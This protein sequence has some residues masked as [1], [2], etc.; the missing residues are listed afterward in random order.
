MRELFVAFQP[1][2]LD[3]EFLA[4]KTAV[5]IDVLR[6]TSSMVQA[7]ASGARRIVPVAEV[8]EAFELRD[9][10]REKPP[11][12]VA[13]ERDGLPPEGFDL[14]NSPQ[15]FTP[16]VVRG[17]TVVMTTTNGSAAILAA[18]PARSVYVTALANA[19]ATA[20]AVA[21]LGSGDTVLVGSGTEGRVSWEDTFCAGALVAR[22]LD[23]AGGNTRHL[24]DSA[25]I[26][27]E[28]WRAVERDP[29]AALR[30]GR[31]G[32]NVLRLGLEAAFEPCA[33][34]DSIDLVARVQRDPVEIVRDRS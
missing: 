29:A 22:L 20:A 32:R 28:A 34:V 5:V 11:P 10:S 6:A 24:T 16:Q 27:L 26:A 14:G 18:L 19:A 31:G 12:L 9:R 23:N 13:G 7:L 25:T 8:R 3:A 1:A 33:A 17:R 4:G 15:E 30:S 2:A 21:G